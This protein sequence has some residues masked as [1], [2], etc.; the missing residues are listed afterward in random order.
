MSKKRVTFAKHVTFYFF[1][2]PLEWDQYRISDVNRI[3][4]DKQRFRDKLMQVEKVINPVLLK[5]IQYLQT[6]HQ[7]GK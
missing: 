5:S 3:I 2:D 7:D 1:C 4:C 6:G